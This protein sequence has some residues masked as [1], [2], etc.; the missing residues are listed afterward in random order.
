MPP[1]DMPAALYSKAVDAITSGEPFMAQ[2][3]LE[4]YGRVLYQAKEIWPNFISCVL[5]VHERIIKEHPDWV[6]KLVDGIA[7]SGK[8]LDEDMEHRMLVGQNVSEKYYNQDPKLLKYVLSTPPDRVTYANLRLAR[9]DFEFIESL[10]KEAG[11]IK[12]NVR[13]ED[14][15]DTTFSEKTVGAKPYDWEG[16]K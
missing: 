12:G 11:I 2:T 9:T 5:V 1:P 15:T 14:Y 13:F 3:Q 10:A 4:G 16:V 8:W 6:Q 7:S